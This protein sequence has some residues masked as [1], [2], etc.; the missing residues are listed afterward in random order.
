LHPVRNQVE[1][2]TKPDKPNYVGKIELKR[3]AEE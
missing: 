3:I 2:N 1:E